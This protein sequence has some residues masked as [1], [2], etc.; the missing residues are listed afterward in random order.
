MTLSVGS[1]DLGVGLNALGGTAF[2][3]PGGTNVSAQDSDA[4]FPACDNLN[5]M[6]DAQDNG[7]V[8][9]PAT[10]DMEGDETDGAGTST[11]LCATLA[12]L[13]D[14]FNGQRE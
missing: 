3:A 7:L 14:L 12:L 13:S 1:S 9:T 6:D 5:G 2:T 10:Y 8:I 4:T 11:D